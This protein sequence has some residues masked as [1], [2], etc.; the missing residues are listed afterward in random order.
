MNPADHYTLDLPAIRALPRAQ[1]LALLDD[2]RRHVTSAV[3]AERARL[4]ADEVAEQAAAHGSHGAQRRAATAL[5]MK[6]ARLSQLWKEHQHMD[7]TTVTRTAYDFGDEIHIMDIDA[8]GVWVE[9]TDE[10]LPLDG[11]RDETLE[12][13][14]YRITGIWSMRGEVEGVEIERS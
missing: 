3:G 8:F 1:A 6:P 14:G 9:G 2:I 4:V 11:D 5:D 13:A 10:V 12:R 7:D